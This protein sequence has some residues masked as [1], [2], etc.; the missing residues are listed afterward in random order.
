MFERPL[1][2]LLT[3]SYREAGGTVQGTLSIADH[4][5]CIGPL[6]G[7]NCLVVDDLADSGS[8][9]AQVIPVIK[10]RYPDIREVR[11]AVLWQKQ[12]SLFSPDY[13]VERLEGNPW[14][15]QPFEVYDRRRPE[16]LKGCD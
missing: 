6:K 11:T 3:S 9:L 16:D 7:P 13:C 8:T 12:H 10:S 14:I 4:V 2:V 1:G 15:H 5:S